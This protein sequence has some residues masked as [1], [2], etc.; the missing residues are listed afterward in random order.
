M[1]LIFFI[2]IIL[3]IIFIIIYKKNNKKNN[4]KGASNNQDLLSLI[5]EAE[6]IENLIEKERDPQKI[7]E[8][9][10]RLE[11]IWEEVSNKK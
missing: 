4:I 5:K 2:I 6:E 8:L 7:L 10:T 11:E 3:F 1:K 9:D